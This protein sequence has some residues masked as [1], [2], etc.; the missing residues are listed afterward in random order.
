MAYVVDKKFA[1]STVAFKRGG[2][3]VR[4][5]ILEQAP[6]KILEE[7]AKKGHPGVIKAQEKEAPK[8]TA[9]KK[10]DKS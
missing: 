5:P 10:A 2:E 6:Q 1:N 4:V 3:M 8:K 9:P 7:L